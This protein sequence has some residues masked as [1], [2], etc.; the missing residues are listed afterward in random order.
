MT[1]PSRSTGRLEVKLDSLIHMVARSLYSDELVCIRELLANAMDAL[2]KRAQKQPDL[3]A[4]PGRLRCQI[5]FDDLDNELVVQDDGIGLSGQEM[6]DFLTV[7]GRSGTGEYREQFRDAAIARRLIGQFGIGVL[8]A[9]IVG[10][11][12]EVVSR[13]AGA[14]ATDGHKFSC[15]QDGGY[16]IESFEVKT[17]GTTVRVEV[18]NPEVARKLRAELEERIRAYSLLLPFPVVGFNGIPVYNVDA[19]R[20]PWRSDEAARRVDEFLRELRVP[21][22]LYQF[23]VRDKNTG[24]GGLVFVP[25][26]ASFLNAQAAADLYVRGMLV[27]KDAV[28]VLPPKAVFL[29]ALL[30]CDSLEPTASR[31][32]V[33]KDAAYVAFRSEVETQILVSLC[34][35]RNELGILGRVLAAHAR[36]F[37]TFLLSEVATRE[38]FVNGQPT[39]L[40]DE[41]APV[42][43]LLRPGD[44]H[45]SVTLTDYELQAANRDDLSQRDKIYYTSSNSSTS[46]QI[47]SVL[48]Q[49][50]I[51]VLV[52]DEPRENTPPPLDYLIVSRYAERNTKKLVAA[53]ERDDLFA[54]VEGDVWR[55]IVEL[56]ED[57]AGAPAGGA[58][59]LPPG[60]KSLHFRATSFEPRNI[61]LL[62][63]ASKHEKLKEALPMFQPSPD[64]DSASRAA[65][66]RIMDLAREQMLATESQMHALINCDNP[67]LQELAR[68]PVREL[69]YSATLRLLALEIVH[70]ALVYSGYA[71]G[72]SA[73]SMLREHKTKLLGLLIRSSDKLD[74]VLLA[75]HARETDR[76]E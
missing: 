70:F 20:V 47:Q 34:A 56:F 32:D 54:A 57:I 13:Q 31:E 35:L 14:A 16:T 27:R 38:V 58:A 74:D 23:L 9:F 62:L 37:K 73:M 22:P 24:V 72:K 33:R 18:S 36:E 3:M 29:T 5:H 26:D 2:T 66:H 50:G 15:S 8:S 39:T 45:P 61:P 7:V 49:R 60:V 68:R 1:Q 42:V 51:T 17:A 48:V 25:A 64:L 41:L 12:L 65:W 44:A 75:E 76:A 30:E 55:L 6:H 21:P 43:P 53:E 10:R 46:V 67:L 59:I 69:Q 11:R 71:F 40:F 4:Q 19:S 28:G 52:L 63:V